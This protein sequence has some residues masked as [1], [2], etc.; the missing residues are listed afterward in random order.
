MS[1]Y[2][3]QETWLVGLEWQMLTRFSAHS[4]AASPPVQW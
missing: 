2:F 4:P 3:M 1:R